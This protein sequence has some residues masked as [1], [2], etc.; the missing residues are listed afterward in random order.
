MFPLICFVLAWVQRRRKRMKVERSAN[1]S[2]LT[3]LTVK[4]FKTS[5]GLS[6]S[7]SFGEPRTVCTA[8]VN[9]PDIDVFLVLAAAPVKTARPPISCRLTE[10]LMFE[11]ARVCLGCSRRLLPVSLILCFR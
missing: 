6:R 1:T 4:P 7:V 5:A 11:Q 10:A 8:P 9:N 3:Q 2:K